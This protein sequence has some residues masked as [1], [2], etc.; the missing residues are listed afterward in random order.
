MITGKINLE[1]LKC[2][3][4]LKKGKSGDVL[5]LVIPIEAN[6]LYQG[7]KGTYLDIVAFEVKN[8]EAGKDTHLVKQSLPADKRTQDQPIIGNLKVS[9]QNVNNVE[10]IEAQV[11]DEEDDLPF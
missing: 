4:Q 2:V 8:P 6:N 3:K 9:G 11:V 1:A 7:Q 5:C 10:V